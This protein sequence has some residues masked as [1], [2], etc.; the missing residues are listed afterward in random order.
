MVDCMSH[1][2]LTQLLSEPIA[3]IKVAADLSARALES[4]SVA[5]PN[6]WELLLCETWRWGIV[7]LPYTA[8]SGKGCTFWNRVRLN[9]GMMRR[10]IIQNSVVVYQVSISAGLGEEGKPTLT[11]SWPKWLTR[12]RTTYIFNASI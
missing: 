2:V 1:I 11:A 10:E 9:Q 8:E 7:G 12:W 3:N 6:E 4:I 5:H